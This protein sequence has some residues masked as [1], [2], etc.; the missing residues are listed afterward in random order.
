MARPRAALKTL[1]IRDEIDASRPTLQGVSFAA[2]QDDYTLRG[3]RAPLQIIRRPQ[4]HAFRIAGEI[5]RSS[6]DRHHAASA[7][8]C[9][10]NIRHDDKRLWEILTCICRCCVP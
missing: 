8:F 10:M 5:S 1:H 3:R 2:Y 4:R 7:M 9:D 6:L